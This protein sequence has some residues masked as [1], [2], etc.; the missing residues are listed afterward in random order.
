[1][2]KVSARYV[3]WICIIGKNIM[4]HTYVDSHHGNFFAT[5][6]HR[7]CY[8]GQIIWDVVSGDVVSGFLSIRRIL[9]VLTVARKI[10]ATVLHYHI[11]CGTRSPA[12]FM[13]DGSLS[14]IFCRGSIFSVHRSICGI[15]IKVG[16]A[17]IEKKTQSKRLLDHGSICRIGS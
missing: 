6:I 4:L 3:L 13:S 8:N 5:F 15:Q 16:F 10:T 1:M 9:Y 17:T 12:W 2:K 11:K 14:I 7:F